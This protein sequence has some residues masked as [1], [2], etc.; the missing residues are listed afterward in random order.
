M[1]RYLLQSPCCML[2]F[3][4]ADFAGNRPLRRVFTGYWC[5]GTAVTS[6]PLNLGDPQ[7]CYQ[8]PGDGQVEKYSCN[9]IPAGDAPTITISAPPGQTMNQSSGGAKDLGSMKMSIALV[10]GWLLH[11]FT[12]VVNF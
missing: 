7:L 1:R 8:Y 10:I 9:G 5:N 6:N 3:S 11:L 4:F 2:I 12:D